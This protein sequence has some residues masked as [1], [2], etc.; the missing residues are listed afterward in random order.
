MVGE[1]DGKILTNHPNPAELITSSHCWRGSFPC[2]DVSTR[3]CEGF[4]RSV[5]MEDIKLNKKGMWID[6]LKI[7]QPISLYL[8][9]VNATDLWDKFMRN[10]TSVPNGILFTCVWEDG[11][12]LLRW[13]WSCSCCKGCG[14][15]VLHAFSPCMAQPWGFLLITCAKP[16]ESS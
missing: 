4:N 14:D 3:T 13:R 6:I 8:C 7:Q 1:F 10:S 2:E 12:L 16:R 15:V 11:F 5:G 9:V